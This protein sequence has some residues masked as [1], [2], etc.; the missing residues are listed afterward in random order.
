MVARSRGY[1]VDAVWTGLF[2]C[3]AFLTYPAMAQDA[4]SVQEETTSSVFPDNN[5]LLTN[6]GGT[7]TAPRASIDVTR[8]NVL[9]LNRWQEDWSIIGKPDVRRVPTDFLKYIPLSRKNPASYLSFGAN[10]RERVESNNAVGFGTG[11]NGRNAYLIQRLQ[12]HMDLHINEHWRGFVQFEDARAFWKGNLAAVDQNPL[13]LRLLFLE[14]KGKVGSATTRVRV[15]RQDFAFDLQRFVSLRDG[16]NVRQSFDA[17][18]VDWES[19]PWRILGFISQPV[20][21]R[22]LRPFDDYSDP[23]LRFSTFR[24]ERHFN[25]QS[26]LSAYYAL[27]QNDHP[28]FLDAAGRENRHVVDVRT[29]GKYDQFNWDVEAMGQ[30]GS[31]GGKTIRAWAFGSRFGNTLSEVPW[32]PWIGMQVDAASGDTHPGDSS[33]GTFNPLFPNGYYF[34]LA[35]YSTYVNVIHVKPIVTVHP[36]ASLAVTGAVG[37]QWRMTTQDAIYT[38]PNIPVAGTAGRG[39]R[40]TGYYGQIRADWRVHSNVAL[41][42]EAVDFITGN[43]IREVGGR[44]SQYLGIEAETSW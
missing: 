18:W 9:G 42:L 43:A 41:A 22:A 37:A 30:F 25:K 26:T 31:I 17:I 36:T 20:Q 12:V 11:S 32:A 15:G 44:D 16:P 10:L 7:A 34:T 29:S 24:I 35:G 5:P 39:G 4:A 13:D 2:A 28:R 8:P 3:L 14:H 23:H 21:Y 33:L 19:K 40:W 1:T 27:Y 6:E 38:Q